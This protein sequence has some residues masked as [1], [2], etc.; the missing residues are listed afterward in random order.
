MTRTKEN[1]KTA[2]EVIKH[3]ISAMN[4]ILGNS[5][6]VTEMHKE[7]APG[8]LGFANNESLLIVVFEIKKI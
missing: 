1:G 5:Y 7:Y 8:K 3:R 4:N 2:D 6:N